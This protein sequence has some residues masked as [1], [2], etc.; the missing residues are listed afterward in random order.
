MYLSAKR[1]ELFGADAEA[2]LLF[3]LTYIARSK[4]KTHPDTDRKRRFF[5][6]AGMIFN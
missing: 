3:R 1:A 5:D 4:A 6:F 2:M